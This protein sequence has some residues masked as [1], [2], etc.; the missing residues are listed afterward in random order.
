MHLFIAREAVDKH[1]QIAG[2]VVLPGKR[3]GA[4]LRGLVRA[5]LFYGGWYRSR[6]AGW[7]YW[8]KYAAFGPLAQ[9]VRY[10]DR[11]RR[12]MARGVFPGLVRLGPKLESRQ[13]VLFR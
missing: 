5:V 11:N 8:P 9:H 7:G 12:R 1:L 13:A 3:R 10:V 2:D 4:R 6:W